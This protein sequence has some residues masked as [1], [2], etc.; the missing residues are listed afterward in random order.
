R[1]LAAAG[2]IEELEA[3]LD[4]DHAHERVSIATRE[5]TEKIEEAL[6]TG[7]RRDALALIESAA[8]ADAAD[9]GLRERAESLR[10]KRAMGPIA[11]LEIRG[12]IRRIVL[13]G[14]IVVGRSEGQIQIPSQAVSRRHL[15]VLRRNGAIIVRDL[16][17]RN[18][19]TLRGMPIANEMPV[20][21]GIEL[22]LGNEVPIT[23]TPCDD[24][25]GAIAIEA[26]GTRYIAPLGA[27]KLGIGDWELACGEGDWL[28][29]RFA[30][31]PAFLGNV[32][33]VSPVTLLVR[34]AIASE[35]DAAPVFEALPPNQ[36]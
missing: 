24:L 9:R 25:E 11:R 19:T 8:K 35:R 3:L 15:V 32:S 21:D 14:E 28:E 20:G 17:S 27:A 12:K 29:L 7:R 5:R 33:L 30:R 18:G 31:S 10:G 13:G 16:E 22:S 2:K 1:A 34:D 6:S 36:G 26:A 4:R 23:I